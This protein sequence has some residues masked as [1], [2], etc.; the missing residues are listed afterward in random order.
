MAL[1]TH[2][3]APPNA[4]IDSS[5]TRGELEYRFGTA[6]EKARTAASSA[7]LLPS[8]RGSFDQKNPKMVMSKRRSW[9]CSRE[10]SW[11]AVRQV[12][13]LNGEERCWAV[14]FFEVV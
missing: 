4:A 12:E 7:S 14:P 5:L 8:R 9:Q 1:R 11:L 6:R 3:I 13:L 2:T 10:A